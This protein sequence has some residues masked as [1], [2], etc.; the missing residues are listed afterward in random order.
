MHTE[1]EGRI[2]KLEVHMLQ[3]KTQA[4]RARLVLRP[5]FHEYQ[6]GA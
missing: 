6:F 5:T 4:L 3:G 1:E 2:S